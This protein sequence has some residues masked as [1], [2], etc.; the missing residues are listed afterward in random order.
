[1]LDYEKIIK[2][3]ERVDWYEESVPKELI[4]VK[5]NMWCE[6]LLHQIHILEGELSD[7]RGTEKD[8]RENTIKN[9][10]NK[11]KT[12]P[13][14]INGDVYLIKKRQFESEM[15]VVEP[16]KEKRVKKTTEKTTKTKEKTLDKGTKNS[17]L[18]FGKNK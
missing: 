8:K 9:L 10:W 11:I 1:M 14:T 18:I 7:L 12:A 17:N 13:Y 3:G 4:N 5:V 2:E 15:A 16:K 6:P